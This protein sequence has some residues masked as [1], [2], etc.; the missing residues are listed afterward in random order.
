MTT[1]NITN[2]TKKQSSLR[3]GLGVLLRVLEKFSRHFIIN[4]KDWVSKAYLR[5]NWTE[6]DQR[7]FERFYN[8]DTLKSARN[9]RNN[10]K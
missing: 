3:V 6:Q 10:E 7:Q 5:D 1:Q 8:F 9:D 2:K 4:S